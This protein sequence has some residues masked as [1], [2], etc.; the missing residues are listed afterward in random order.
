VFVRKAAPK[1]RKAPKRDAKGRFTKDPNRPRSDAPAWTD[2]D[3][4]R[5][6]RRLVDDPNSGLTADERAEIIE[7]GYRGPTRRNPYTGEMETMELSHEPIPRREGGTDVVP[8]WPDDHA[9]RD[10]DR[11]LK[12]NRPPHTYPEEE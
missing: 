3:R 11:K 4:R 5:E 8:A 12:G 6:W 2:A 10:P 7:R 1:F 9:A